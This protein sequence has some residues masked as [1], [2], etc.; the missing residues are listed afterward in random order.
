M[1]VPGQIQCLTQNRM[2]R[3]ILETCIRNTEEAER[4]SLGDAASIQSGRGEAKG[5]WGMIE[6][7]ELAKS[8]R[9]DD[10]KKVD[11]QT[12]ILPSL[13]RGPTNILS[14]AQ[15]E[16]DVVLQARSRKS[17]LEA[18]LA[19]SSGSSSPA[20]PTL[21]PNSEMVKSTRELVK[22]VVALI[23]RTSDPSQLE[24]LLALNDDLMMLLGR[25]EPRPEPLK[26]QGL[27][28]LLG[29]GDAMG[30]GH[31]EVIAT[32][33]SA[34]LEEGGPDDDDEDDEPIT[35]RV[36]KGK[37]RA[38]PEPEP[39]ESVLSPT[40]LITESDDEDGEAVARSPESDVIEDVVSPVDL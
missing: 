24:M 21:D 27:G 34:S 13:S 22:S 10:K 40:F 9:E 2:C 37:G 15:T 12:D 32:N 17:E 33:G 18:L 29:N 5:V 25:L 16:S 4:A 19:Q 14:A 31:S 6:Q 30:N 20:R 23:E 11:E 28:I 8:I 26:I 3:D 39:Q 7:S 1:R 36:D 38:E 35:P